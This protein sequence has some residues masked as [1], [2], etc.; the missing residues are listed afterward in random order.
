MEYL[1][2][3]EQLLSIRRRAW[4]FLGCFSVANLFLFW[5]LFGFHPN[6][7]TDSYIISIEYFRGQNTQLFPNRYLNP[8]YSLVGATILRWLSPPMVLIVLNIIFYFGLTVLT[9][10]LF[11]RVFSSRAVGIAAT[12]VLITGYPLLRYGLTQVQDIGGYF[13]FVLTLY[14]GWRWHEEDKTKWLLLGSA[15][16]SGGLLTKESGA[17]GALFFAVLIILSS[18]SIPEKLKRLSI[19][20]S[21]ASVTLLINIWRGHLVGYSSLQ[22]FIDNWKVYGPGNYNFFKWFGVNVTTYNATWL[23]AIAGTWLLAVKKQ[24]LSPSVKLY[25]LAVFIP[26]LSYFA[27]PLFIGRTVFISAWLITPLAALTIVWLLRRNWILGAAAWLLILSMPYILQELFR[28]VHFFQ[29][30][31]ICHYQIRCSWNF[32]WENRHTFSEIL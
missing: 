9:Y 4:F 14:A 18:L 7:D 6:N 23:F 32:F 8:F 27:W 15:A 3:F 29:I 25:F 1:D 20:A 26:S 17:M 31:D 24:W 13:W 11:R 12:S 22:W 28:Y 10:D 30:F 16:I 2:K 5:W 19:V 21:I